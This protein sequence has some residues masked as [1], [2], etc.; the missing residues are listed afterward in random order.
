MSHIAFLGLGAMGSRM[1]QQLLNH[2]HQVTLWNRTPQPVK[3]VQCPNCQTAK[4]PAL[5]VNGADFVFSMLKDDQAA[6]ETWLTPAHGAIHAMPRTAI[7]IECSTLSNGM[8]TELHQQFS[9]KA[10][11]F[12]H[13]PVI[14]SRPHAENAQLITLLG[15]STY[16]KEKV[17]PLVACYSA[18]LIPLDTPE[19]AATVKL[20]VNTLFAIQVTA[21]AEVTASFVHYDKTSEFI[22]I[23]TSLPI[24]SPALNA[25][26]QMIK[27]QQ[28]AP[29]FP[30]EL[31][32]K[33][34]NY[35]LNNR[36]QQGA[37][38]SNNNSLAATTQALFEHAVGKGYGADNITGIAQ[39]WQ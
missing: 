14:G 32:T 22:D 30:I 16:A 29:L 26:A 4:T 37:V 3:D 17:S 11:E 13:A 34:L 28:F 21:L 8:I 35:F 7:A 27:S 24:C 36:A 20:A 38:L 6:Q 23:I 25:A 1:A 12:I 39:L 19:Q 33:D 18:K 2:G 31:V 5:A 10:I 9:H 15:G